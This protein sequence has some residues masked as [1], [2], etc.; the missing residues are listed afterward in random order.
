[1]KKLFLILAAAVALSSCAS[2]VKN[3]TENVP[4]SP[5]FKSEGISFDGSEWYH[6][7]FADKKGITQ[8]FMKNKP[9]IITVKFGDG[10][11]LRCSCSLIRGQ[12]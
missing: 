12:R 8:A 7:H 2:K 1:M 11:H 9:I 4:P 5:V 10:R 3:P 6:V